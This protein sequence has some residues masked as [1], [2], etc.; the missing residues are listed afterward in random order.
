MLSTAFRT[1]RESTARE[2]FNDNDRNL[3]SDITRFLDNYN[4]R[5]WDITEQVSKKS[6]AEIKRISEYQ[7]RQGKQVVVMAGRVIVI[8]GASA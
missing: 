3:P 2:E 5:I 7:E 8:G 6:N 4:A 1:N